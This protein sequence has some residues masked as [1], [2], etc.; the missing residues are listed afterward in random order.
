MKKH[1]LIYRI[2]QV[3]FCSVFMLIGNLSTVA[4]APEKM[5][6][7]AV[8]RTPSNALV[9]NQNVG[10]RISILQG[11]TTGASVYQETH[12]ATTNQHGLVGIEIGSG[13]VTSGVFADIDWGN[14]T[15]FLKSE[16]DPTGS[17]NYTISGVS[18]LI[19]V[20]YALFSQRSANGVPNPGNEGQVLTICNGVPTWTTNGQCPPE[21][22]DYPSGHVN[23]NTSNPTVIVDVYNPATN[24]TWMDRNLGATRAA[25]NPTDIQAYGSYFQWGR[26]ADGHQCVHLFSGDGFW[27]SSTTTVLSNDLNPGHGNFITS[28]D[29]PFDWRTSNSPTPWHGVNGI[30]NPCPNGYRLPTAAE[31]NNELLTWSSNDA[32][33]AFTSPLK[34]TASGY[35]AP[36]GPM[37]NVNVSGRYWT[38]GTS[39]FSS[40]EC[41]SFNSTSALL[42]TSTR[43]TGSSVRCIKEVQPQQGSIGNLNCWATNTN[44]TLTAGVPANSV[45]SN[46]SYSVGL[47][48]SHNGQVV[49]ST[50]VTGLT[51]TLPAGTIQFGSGSLTYNISGTPSS[52]GTASFALNIGGQS[53]ILTIQVQAPA[54]PQGTV[55]ALNCNAA[56][57]NGTLTF[58]V[59]A[60]GVSSSVPYDGGNGGS[61]NGQVVSS[62]GVT[63]L[64]ATLSAGSFANGTGSLI[65]NIS[66]TP[67]SAGTASFALNIGGQSCNLTISV[68]PSTP[69]F[70]VGYV[71]CNLSN[72]TQ[73]VDVLNPATNK[74]WMDR[75]LGSNRAALSSTD[76]E[77][78]GS[79]FQW[80]RAADGHQCV[81]RYAGDGV[82]TSSI[83]GIMS[84]SDTPGHGNF[85]VTQDVPFDWRSPQNA[86]LWQGV[87]GVN[88]P[89][90]SGYRVPTQSEFENEVQSWTQAPINSTNNSTGAFASPLKLPLAGGR[91][92]EFLFPEASSGNYWT[93]TTSATSAYF[94]KF[95][96]L[97]ASLDEFYRNYGISVRCIKD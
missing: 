3:V 46:V 93:S 34:L 6:Y 5:S 32:L 69:A 24:Q 80:G 73:V 55:N 65:Y 96:N 20:P 19:S 9:V 75:N 84:S 97:N 2:I 27:T 94:M 83:T 59:A 26:S 12:V 18:Q 74:T 52:A 33:G 72:P 86:N 39:L 82:T 62:T 28:G 66:G 47:G 41:L 49:T 1:Y 76:T 61:H 56:S 11:S 88:N 95:N 68:Q 78:Y 30:N 37:N 25:I 10:M 92:Q 45:S 8:V 90:P 40:S 89:C 13:N 31:L 63:G 44:G 14:G 81:H 29:F 91:V 79:L 87:N 42:T 17:T 64:T 43:S 58:G 60:S 38:S 67:A 35:R 71:Q 57:T 16:I 51:A 85:I 22:T 77:S 21:Q 15:F 7:Q 36:N 70:P 48:G 53:C 54:P 50:G 4:Q 23:C